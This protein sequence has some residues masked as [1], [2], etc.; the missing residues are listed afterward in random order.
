MVNWD[1]AFSDRTGG[2]FSLRVGSANA[3]RVSS[4]AVVREFEKHQTSAPQGWR[5]WLSLLIIVL[6]CADFSAY[7]DVL[8]PP[9]SKEHLEFRIGLKNFEVRCVGYKYGKHVATRK[10]SVQILAR[11]FTPSLELQATCQ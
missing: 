1:L 10:R 6:D 9:G 5:R 4:V 2:A 3:V 7:L 8:F 11:F